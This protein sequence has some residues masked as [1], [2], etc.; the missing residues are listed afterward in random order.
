MKI[1]SI[2]RNNR[3]I[4]RITGSNPVGIIVRFSRSKDRVWVIDLES[5]SDY[6]WIVRE[7][8]TI[9]K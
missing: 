7:C 9:F 8:L 5:G 6:I 2:V 1:G 4:N 3:I